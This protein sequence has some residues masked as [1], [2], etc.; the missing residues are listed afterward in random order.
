ML[1]RVADE[2]SELRRLLNAA[3]NPHAPTCPRSGPEPQS[4][5][6]RTD[7]RHSH[8]FA[9]SGKDAACACGAAKHLQ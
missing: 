7:N 4:R 5:H 9:V 1:Q 2:N 8:G 3:V 6:G